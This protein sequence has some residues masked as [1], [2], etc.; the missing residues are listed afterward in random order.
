MTRY[1][2]LAL[3]AAFALPEL[4]LIRPRLPPSLPTL[5][6]QPQSKLRP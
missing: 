3:L 5:P 2:T 1:L 6:R 4:R